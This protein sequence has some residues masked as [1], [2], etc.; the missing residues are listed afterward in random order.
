MGHGVGI[1]HT[2]DQ[3]QPTDPERTKTALL[4]VPDLNRAF[5]SRVA[6]FDELFWARYARQPIDSKHLTYTHEEREALSELYPQI[7]D[8]FEARHGRI[9]EEYW[10]TSVPAGLVR[11]LKGHGPQQDAECCAIVDWKQC[12]A[13]L[14]APMLELDELEIGMEFLHPGLSRRQAQHL[15]FDAYSS[16]LDAL[17]TRHTD[18]LKD[19]TAE[20]KLIERQVALARQYFRAAAQRR[21]RAE[22]LRGLAVGIVVV[23]SMSALAATSFWVLGV[24]PSS[25]PG[26][27]LAWATAGAVGACLS[28]LVRV[29]DN[30]F[31]PNWE[32]TDPE[33]WRDGASRPVVGAIFGAVIPMFVISGLAALA[34][35]L[36]DAGDVKTQLAYLSLGF[37]AG[38]SERWARDLI[39][40]QPSVLAAKGADV[41][42]T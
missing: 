34:T 41:P 42:E 31:S 24:D 29:A 37:G 8:M 14:V 7:R 2:R 23:L 40:K 21:A 22:S 9:E 38:F 18:G 6:T 20:I 1:S 5:A 26:R 11:T 25:L 13:D 15:I 28:V 17:E 12:D 30:D 36:K 19:Q 27:L 39:A 10:C 33:L 16:A 4:A 35:D 3:A 32:A